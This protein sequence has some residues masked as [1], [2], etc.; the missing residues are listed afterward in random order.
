MVWIG[1]EPE[2]TW[3]TGGNVHEVSKLGAHKVHTNKQAFDVVT[4]VVSHEDLSESA[5]V[6]RVCNP[7]L[8]RRVCALRRPLTISLGARCFGHL[9]YHRW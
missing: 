1:G 5:R 2:L 8:H 3:T 9:L 6:R 7:C 4:A